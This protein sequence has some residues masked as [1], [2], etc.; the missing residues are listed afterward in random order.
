MIPPKPKKEVSRVPFPDKLE[1]DVL[2]KIREKKT[3]EFPF[4]SPAVSI[5]KV[6][7][8][9]ILMKSF[10]DFALR[11][12]STGESTQTQSMPHECSMDIPIP[13]V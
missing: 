11:A 3:K 12:L 5:S 4:V 10:D 7:G 6:I 8:D 2:I 1:I 13:L 9:A